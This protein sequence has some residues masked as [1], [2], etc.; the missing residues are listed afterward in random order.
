MQGR[1]LPEY[2]GMGGNKTSPWG[3]APCTSP[4]G[5][6]SCLFTGCSR[7]GWLQCLDTSRLVL[8]HWECPSGIASQARGLWEQ[9]GAVTLHGLTEDPQSP[10][11]RWQGGAGVS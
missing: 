6:G 3:A 1:Q 5:S 2:Q 9:R 11:A 10:V 7:T 8:W 4:G